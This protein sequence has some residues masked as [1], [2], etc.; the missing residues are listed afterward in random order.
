M[1]NMM[2]KSVCRDFQRGHFRYGNNCRFSHIDSV[3]KIIDTS[4]YGSKTK[5]IDN[6]NKY[7][8]KLKRVNTETVDPSHQLAIWCST[9]AAWITM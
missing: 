8:Q 2:D 4:D 6:K 7:K 5:H 1:Y 3:K 9:I